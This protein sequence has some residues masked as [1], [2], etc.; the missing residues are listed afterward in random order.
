MR[1][2]A[3]ARRRF[4]RTS[5]RRP[6]DAVYPPP[7]SMLGQ[8]GL[9]A[10]DLAGAGGRG[11]AVAG[12][13]LDL[14]QCAALVGE[15]R[16][17]FRSLARHAAHDVEVLD[18]LSI[19]A[20]AQFE[21]RALAVLALAAGALLPIT[22]VETVGQIPYAVEWLEAPHPRGLGDHPD[23]PVGPPAC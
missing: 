21:R 8:T 6:D 9:A 12:Q 16:H 2:A 3:T 20:L 1:P 7:V 15:G 18:R 17:S 23:D 11:A 19:S 5:R 14:R 22:V 10:G 4:S 13:P